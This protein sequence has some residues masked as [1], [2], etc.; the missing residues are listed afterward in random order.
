MEHRRVEE[1]GLR[2]IDN[3]CPGAGRDHATKLLL[4]LWSR[5]EVVLA[6]ERDDEDVFAWPLPPDRVGGRWST[7]PVPNRGSRDA[8]SRDACALHVVLAAV[9]GDER[10]RGRIAR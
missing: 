6:R 1:G 10:R 4:H 3:D 7:C 5:I 9:E 8:C 2:Q